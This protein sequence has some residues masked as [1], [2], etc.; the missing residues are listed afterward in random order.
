[1]YDR[2]GNYMHTAGLIR[3]VGGGLVDLLGGYMD[4]KVQDRRRRQQEEF[5]KKRLELQAGATKE[6][7]ERRRP[8]LEALGE[9]ANISPEELAVMLPQERQQYINMM[10]QQQQSD[11]STRKKFGMG[12]LAQQGFTPVQAE[13][14]YGKDITGKTPAS[15]PSDLK[16]LRVETNKYENNKLEETEVKTLE[17]GL[18][19]GD[20][21]ALIMTGAPLNDTIATFFQQHAIARL[22][23]DDSWADL[24]ILMKKYKAEKIAKKFASRFKYTLPAPKKPS[25]QELKASRIE[26]RQKQK[27]LL[28]QQKQQM[29]IK[30]QQEEGLQQRQE[31]QFNPFMGQFRG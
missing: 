19:D 18:K 16:R 2:D 1:M 14:Y 31:E 10:L 11:E 13:K 12:Q 24:P 30:R 22:G 4:S 17:D 6:E 8:S 21:R 3:D 27:E 7:E 29:R 26:Q 5:Y 9:K 25:A 28:R 20:P 23:Q 15:L